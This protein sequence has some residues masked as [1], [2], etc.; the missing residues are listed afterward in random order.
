MSG[1]KTRLVSSSGVSIPQILY[2]TAWKK[3]RTAPLVATAIR[4][5]FRGIDTA[6][7]PKHYNEP[8]V[9]EG[10]AL[11]LDTGLTRSDLYIQ[12]KFTPVRGQDP[13]N[14]PYD[15]SASLAQQVSQ[16]LIASLRN[17]RTDVLDCLLLHSPLQTEAQMR[18]VWQAMEAGVDSGSVRQLGISNCYELEDL[19]WLYQAARIKPAVVQNRFY[20]E[21]G[22]DRSIRTFCRERGILYEGFWIITA[23]PHL[24]AHSVFQNLAA[25]YQCSPAHILF[26]ALIQNDIIPLIGTT[27]EAHMHE[28]Q[29]IFNFELTQSECAQIDKLM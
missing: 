27:S 26:R 1:E 9:G 21:T 3:D 8:G 28:D 19:E 5:G 15:P 12:S 10:I 11:A 7:Q 17:L 22:Y 23:N 25:H 18:E 4:S 14:I 20:Q 13:G 24:L 2:G 29:E 16:S 6:C